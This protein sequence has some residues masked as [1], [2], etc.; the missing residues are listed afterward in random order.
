[1]K[2]VNKKFDS[3]IPQVPKNVY[4]NEYMYFS[5]T[6][7]DDCP[8]VVKLCSNNKIVMMFMTEIAAKEFVDKHNARVKKNN[9]ESS[10]A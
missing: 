7:N 3:A 2:I 5:A 6:V 10:I 4:E 9:N 8:W 1:M